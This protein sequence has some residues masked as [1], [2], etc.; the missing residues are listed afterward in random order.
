MT[1]TEG[2]RSPEINRI[3]PIARLATSSGKW[4]EAWRLLAK[5]V[6][7]ASKMLDGL[8]GRCFRRGCYRQQPGPMSLS[9]YFA[10]AVADAA[11]RKLEEW[12]EKLE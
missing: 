3:R 1:T 2:A 12:I 4:A 9:D 6:W 7:W 10:P 11:R 5:W 8:A